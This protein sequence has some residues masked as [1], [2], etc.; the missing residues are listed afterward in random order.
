M[1][2]PFKKRGEGKQRKH[3]AKHASDSDGK[4]SKNGKSREESAPI[5]SAAVSLIPP[6]KEVGS[7]SPAR[8]PATHEIREP[9]PPSSSNSGTAASSDDTKT[10]ELPQPPT[11]IAGSSGNGQKTIASELPKLPLP[12]AMRDGVHNQSPKNGTTS[13]KT[14]SHHSSH[15]HHHSGPTGAASRTVSFAKEKGQKAAARIRQGLRRDHGATGR[16]HRF[17]SS[18]SSRNIFASSSS[19][20]AEAPDAHHHKDPSFSAIS[21]IADIEI[22]AQKS[23]INTATERFKVTPG[24][25]YP[26]VKMNRD[27]LR[28]ECR[29]TSS[30]FHTFRSVNEK[31][32]VTTTTSPL[33]KREDHLDTVGRDD[34]SD[35]SIGSIPSSSVAAAGHSAAASNRIY[36]HDRSVIGTLAVEIMQCF[37]IPRPELLKESTAFCVCVCGP[38]AFQTDVM[39]PVANPMWLSKMRRACIFPLYQAYQKLYVGVFCRQQAN[40]KDGF[41]GRVSI[42]V[43]RLR[44]GS[45]YDITLPIRMFAHI[46]SRQQ[47]GSIRLRFHLE[48]YS[49]QRAVLSYMPNISFLK[50]GSSKKQKAKQLSNHH[51]QAQNA[52]HGVGSFLASKVSAY[53]GSSQASQS[54]P[55][56]SSHWNAMVG[57][58]SK[59]SDAA[60]ED[61]SKLDEDEIN[62]LYDY[63]ETMEHK[64][65][66]NSANDD[67]D[68]RSISSFASQ[69]SRRGLRRRQMGRQAKRGG[70]SSIP[71]A[72]LLSQA[73]PVATATNGSAKASVHQPAPLPQPT[74]ACCDAKAF[75]NVARVVHGADMPGKFSM[76][77]VKA[78]AREITF[79]Q[80][81][82]LRYFRKRELYHLRTWKSPVIS[83]F[84]FTAWMHCIWEGNL[85]Y[86]PGHLVTLFLLYMWRS[87]GMYAIDSKVTCGFLS[88]TWEELFWSLLQGGSTNEGDKG[89]V[90]GGNN[91]GD[92]N[93][94]DKDNGMMQHRERAK[95]SR[96][97]QPI[98]MVRKDPN[99]MKTAMS[100]F[101]QQPSSD[102]KTENE[103]KTPGG[104]SG[105]TKPQETPLRDI[106]ASF[107]EGVP[108][109]DYKTLFRS[110]RG[111]FIGARAVQFLVEHGYSATRAEAVTLGLKL[112]KDLKLFAPVHGFKDFEDG[113]S[114]YVFLT[115]KNDSYEIKTK[116]PLGRQLLNAIGFANPPELSQ[117]D[118]HLEFPFATGKDHARF[119]VKES[120][121]IRSKQSKRLLLMQAAHDEEEA[122]FDKVYKL[123]LASKKKNLLSRVGNV[124]P[125]G[126]SSNASTPVDMRMSLS[127]DPGAMSQFGLSPGE[128]G[129][130]ESTVNANGKK[131]VSL[132]QSFSF[133]GSDSSEEGDFALLGGVDP[134]HGDDGLDDD[135]EDDDYVIETKT[136]N[137]PPPQDINKIQKSDKKLPDTLNEAKHKLHAVMGHVFND[138]VYQLPKLTDA[139]KA[140]LRRRITF[141]A[142]PS[143]MTGPRSVSAP[144]ILIGGSKSNNRIKKHLGQMGRSSSRID[145]GSSL[146]RSTLNPFG[147]AD[148]PVSTKEEDL[149]YLAELRNEHDKLL[150]INKYSH[151]NIILQRIA[152]I[153]QPI[154][155]MM[156]AGLCFFRCMFNA[157]TWRDPY[158]SFWITLVGPVLVILLHVF[159][160]RMASLV[161]G[162]VLVGPQNYFV[163]LYKEK[164]GIAEE[165]DFDALTK[166]K[167]IGL[168]SVAEYEP[169]YFSSQAPDNRPVHISHV[170]TSHPR[171][172]V[173]PNSPL[174]YSRFYDW[175]PE[176]DYSRIYACAPPRSEG[177][178]AAMLE[179]NRFEDIEDATLASSSRKKKRWKK[180]GKAMDVRRLLKKKDNNTTSK[181]EQI[182]E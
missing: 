150:G 159:P 74:I 95:R 170:D 57:A 38:H 35:T 78:T 85:K 45:T 12:S 145:E 25:A 158:L 171:T 73:E 119:T 40:S 13:R 174:M 72:K 89:A 33:R 18:S 81:H 24:Y 60:A 148:D 42:D 168:G 164:N 163:R 53:W 100:H 77:R 62:R 31:G 56:S 111:C 122:E 136:L 20:S 178:A 32:P 146:R 4:T 7:F 106:A 82:I 1:K 23:G 86:L 105:N 94:N 55:P 22:L 97:M 125:G 152:V 43:C 71:A 9:S 67:D 101:Q 133:H 165:P 140:S 139:T 175:P 87:Y 37:G 176:P 34:P 83:G 162:F 47:R 114:Y 161:A 15:Q 75:Q 39:P 88:L 155:E 44:P 107:R 63:G 115:H 61:E 98:E 14:L 120:L 27:E 124:R 144:P 54:S 180:V 3:Q 99:S 160:W 103:G 131:S 51:Y 30:Y 143:A 8:A 79:M 137:K 36:Q 117:S 69:S 19:S 126:G 156:L 157:L 28:A 112:Q 50:F 64:N 130:D 147:S 2:L 134:F 76:Q 52:I 177:V 104:T 110:H 138:K 167:K 129:D 96:M 127:N 132:M 26:N 92:D 118:A 149:A 179:S 172:V 182:A 49:E 169:N 108:T 80:I 21:G 90:D 29:K 121:V 16:R 181:L 102:D 6:D 70:L 109:C 65:A 151:S 10:S 68:D 173:V 41:A 59:S 48:W 141:A 84:V 142:R 135:L 46:Y 17:S 123:G 58:K 166:K 66:S 11:S 93:D 128:D 91:D 116:K 154:L 113:K 153:V 5:T